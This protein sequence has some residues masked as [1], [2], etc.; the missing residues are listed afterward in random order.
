VDVILNSLAGEFFFKSTSIM[1]PYGRFLEI[2]KRNFSENK[3]GIFFDSNITQSDTYLDLESFTNNV[4]FIAV[5]FDAMLSQKT[6]LC[7]KIL[8]EVISSP[9]A[10]LLCL[11]PFTIPTYT[12]LRPKN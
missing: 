2:G 5:D 8:K 7:G 12:Y 10:E 3:L 11:F 4:S 1:A 9:Y 6:S